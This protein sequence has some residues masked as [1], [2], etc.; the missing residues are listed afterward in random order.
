M[1]LEGA[2][3]G[4]AVLTEVRALV[5]CMRDRLKFYKDGPERFE[6]LNG[7][8]TRL[9]GVVDNIATIS[10]AYQEVLPKEIAHVF[11]ETIEDVR[12]IVS[13]SCATVNLYCSKAFDCKRGESLLYSARNAGA[14]ACSKQNRCPL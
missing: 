12:Q 10:R 2:G 13:H 5:V 1:A 14:F 9:L 11:K 3:V 4:F 7:T 8:V 6:A